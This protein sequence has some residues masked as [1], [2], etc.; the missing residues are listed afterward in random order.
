M[1]GDLLG[2]RGTRWRVVPLTGPVLAPPV[3]AGPDAS[4]AGEP[5]RDSRLM[6]AAE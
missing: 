2:A 1:G 5:H 3:D 4:E 6:T